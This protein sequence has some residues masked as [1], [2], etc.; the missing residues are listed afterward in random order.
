MLL[1][2]KKENHTQDENVFT[3]YDQIQA[4]RNRL[5][6]FKRDE[7]TFNASQTKMLSPYTA[8]SHTKSFQR[9]ASNENKLNMQKNTKSFLKP[10]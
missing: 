4:T 2:T 6:R 5:R 9:V 8:G 3:A 7:N 1:H 10:L